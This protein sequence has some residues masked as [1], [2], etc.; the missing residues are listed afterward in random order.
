MSDDY[1]SY[2]MF[3]GSA[4]K[5]GI[6]VYS[7]FLTMSSLF[8][9]YGKLGD[10]R[11]MEFDVEL[12]THVPLR[13]SIAGIGE[14]DGILGR[15]R[16]L[17]NSRS[18][19]EVF[20]ELQNTATDNE[21]EQIMGRTGI[22]N[23]TISVFSIMA[24][25]GID[26]TSISPDVVKKYGLKITDNKMSFGN[27]LLS[28]NIVKEIVDKLEYNNSNL[29][30]FDNKQ[31]IDIIKD[32]KKKLVKEKDIKITDSDEIL[33]DEEG[34]IIAVNTQDNFDLLTGDNLVEM[35]ASGE[36]ENSNDFNYQVLSL[37]EKLYSYQDQFRNAQKILN[38]SSNGLGLDLIENNNLNELLKKVVDNKR[39]VGIQK[40]LFK[41]LSE[42]DVTTLSREEKDKVVFVNEFSGG[43]LPTT[44]IGASILNAFT[45]SKNLWGSMF[46][47]QDRVYRDAIKYALEQTNIKGNSKS[48]VNFERKFAKEFKKY[49]NSRTVLFNGSVKEERERL[50]FDTPDN[51]S[52]ACY[53]NNLVGDNSGI[54]DITAKT[55]LNNPLIK[56]FK[57]DI[58]L[59]NK[60]N[61]NNRYPS[62]IK[63]N[64]SNS[65]VENRE[66]L[67]RA[68]PE[69]IELDAVLPL[70]NGKP[71]T[72]RMLAQDLATYAF[73][74]GGIQEVQQFV[75]YIPITYLE[76]IG[77][78]Q[79]M[80]NKYNRYKEYLATDNNG[81]KITPSFIRQF[82][83][84]NPDLVKRVKNINGI[85]YEAAKTQGKI[86][87]FK[88]DFIELDP[89]TI[90]DNDISK[91]DFISFYDPDIKGKSKYILFEKVPGTIS[92]YRKLDS[93][94]FTN[95]SEYDSTKKEVFTLKK[96]AKPD[97]PNKP[98]NNSLQVENVE[99]ID[100]F[101]IGEKDTL[102]VVE[103]LLQL[104][105]DYTKV[106]EPFINFIPKG[107]KIEIGETS[108]TGRYSK[109]ENKITIHPNTINK[110]SKFLSRIL[111]KELIHAT[112]NSYVSQFLNGDGSYIN[113]NNIENVP[114]A[115]RKLKTL[116]D[117]LFKIGLGVTTEST[118]KSLEDFLKG[119]D[120][121]KSI[122]VEEFY[123]FYG[124][125]D[126]HEFMEM[127]MTEPK[128]REFLDEIST[129]D[130]KEKGISFLDRLKDAFKGIWNSLT[131]NQVS[132]EVV[133]SISEIIL[134]NKENT[135]PINDKKDEF[136]NSEKAV[137]NAKNLLDNNKNSNFTD[138]NNSPQLEEDPFK[139]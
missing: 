52:L 8:Q 50:F 35:I 74:E 9:Q 93:A 78:T 34:G 110:G 7:N 133:E 114:L 103:N 82:Y 39:L 61:I 19:S 67:Y 77:F 86:D 62:V 71:Y 59:N 33:Y 41:N 91:S 99:E 92:K 131:H 66:I 54:K 73:L 58:N 106:F 108:G 130:S 128:F 117:E 68:L 87:I 104:D 22:N 17:D 127:S 13:F 5:S 116:Y 72:T 105:N 46:P 120:I 12:E 90:A 84:H 60:K 136:E 47:Y 124:F 30:D 53:L 70:Y 15:L 42:V 23:H 40:L 16:T 11:L 98:S 1:Q 138:E 69:L 123:K 55:L 38:I 135:E 79:D 65:I 101:G 20:E 121:K 18:I 122:N 32:I 49:L 26:K 113:P 132:K 28:Q 115:V 36:I 94:G 129:K 10:F 126:I 44:P 31:V 137:I 4:G 63:Y 139:C 112:T 75:K 48:K 119:F 89:I 96:V 81:I 95:L 37:L 29:T 76:A 57:F 97:L 3:L 107:L 88:N 64:D 51:T 85:S 80:L 21:K 56:K 83:Q 100:T 111:V 109:I 43:L 134:S 118:K 6:G 14:I 24:M 25:L 102:T 45:M 125:K 2:K 27:L